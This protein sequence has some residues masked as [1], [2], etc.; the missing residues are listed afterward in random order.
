MDQVLIQRINELAS[1]KKTSGL[2]I[3]EEQE[4]KR[5]YKEYIAHIKGQ[6]KAQLDQ[7]AR[8]QNTPSCGCDDPNCKHHH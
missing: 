8:N 2:S 1:K 3:E 5:L 7:A 6:V 4:Q